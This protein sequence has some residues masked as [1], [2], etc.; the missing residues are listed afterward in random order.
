MRKIMTFMVALAFLGALASTSSAYNGRIEALGGVDILPDNV[1]VFRAWPGSIVLYK[2]RA[3]IDVS[4]SNQGMDTLLWGGATKELWGG[5]VLGL[6]GN[7]TTPANRL[8]AL[9]GYP[10]A[11]MNGGLGVHLICDSNIDNEEFSDKT[12]VG[13]G[14]WVHSA[15]TWTDEDSSKILRF[16]ALL[17][18]NDRLRV[19]LG[20]GLPF[21]STKEEY[22]DEWAHDGDS[23]GG[24]INRVVDKYSIIA[25]STKSMGPIGIDGRLLYSLNETTKVGG[26]VNIATGDNGSEET[27]EY[28]YDYTSN[29]DGGEKQVYTDEVTENDNSVTGFRVAPGMIVDVSPKT[30]VVMQLGL[31]SGKETDEETWTDRL[32]KVQ[33]SHA[34]RLQK[35][36]EETETTETTL[37]EIGVGVETQL[38]KKVKLRVGVA[39]SWAKTTEKTTTK[40]TT[41]NSAGD[42]TTTTQQ[43]EETVDTNNSSDAAV[44]VGLGYRPIEPLIIDANINMGILR[45]DLLGSDGI[46]GGGGNGGINLLGDGGTAGIFVSIFATY[47]FN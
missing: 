14:G 47:L 18:P 40:T 15:T 10:L 22:I 6:Y 11:G 1:D 45:N 46:F 43:E 12:A 23:S 42:G 13:D 4:T 27:T 3:H 39:S 34:G 17:R 25:E 8:E 7:A 35:T 33:S 19:D 5:V 29:S 20:L 44:T 2:E 41:I 30:T 32:V 26:V 21:C 28:G 31:G 24:E 37:P 16:G 9:L 38:T 36:V